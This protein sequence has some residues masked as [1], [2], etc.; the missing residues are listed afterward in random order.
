[1][2]GNNTIDNKNSIYVSIVLG[3]TSPTTNAYQPNPVYIKEGQTII[4]I[5]GS[6]LILSANDTEII[7][8]IH[9]FMEFQARE[10]HGH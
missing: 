2:N 5:N 4:W 7:D 6:S 1:M 9:P 3:A 10:H 8:A